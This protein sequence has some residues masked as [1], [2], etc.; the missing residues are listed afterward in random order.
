MLAVFSFIRAEFLTL[1][2]KNGLLCFLFRLGNKMIFKK[3]T[4]E[5]WL[6]YLKILNIELISDFSATHINRQYRLADRAYYRFRRRRAL[7]A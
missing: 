7:D 1:K 6:L 4:M 3:L 5:A 2:T